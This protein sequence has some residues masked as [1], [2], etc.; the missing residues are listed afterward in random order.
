MK[1]CSNVIFFNVHD[2][3]L[4]GNSLT[5]HQWQT[6]DLATD[7]QIRFTSILKSNPSTLKLCW[8][9]AGKSQ[10]CPYLHSGT[11]MWQNMRYIIGIR[12][13]D[14]SHIVC[15]LL[16]KRSFCTRNLRCS[17]FI[18][19]IAES[20]E[21]KVVHRSFCSAAQPLHT[22]PPCRRSRSVFCLRPVADFIGDLFIVSHC[23]DTVVLPLICGNSGKSQR[24]NICPLGQSDQ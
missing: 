15:I 2:E 20:F 3:R 24:V 14:A 17:Q 23:W 13:F 11:E 12:V 6:E 19:F 7:D 9:Q 8:T 18:W 10:Q 5:V 21:F 22:C 16:P 4:Y 1:K